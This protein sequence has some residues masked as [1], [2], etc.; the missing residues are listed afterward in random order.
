MSPIFVSPSCGPSVLR[1]YGLSEADILISVF[2]KGDGK[3]EA[4]TTNGLRVF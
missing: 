2:V 3:P 4:F 1:T